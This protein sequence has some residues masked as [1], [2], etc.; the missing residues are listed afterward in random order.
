MV[1]DDVGD[2]LA[3]AGAG[4]AVDDQALG[5]AGEGD[6]AGLAGVGLGDEAFAGEDFGAPVG[7]VDGRGQVRPR[8]LVEADAGLDEALYRARGGFASD[9]GLGVAEEARRGRA[10]GRGR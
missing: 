7:W 2:G 9:E 6:G 1:A 10:A 4:R 3:L 8:G 5:S